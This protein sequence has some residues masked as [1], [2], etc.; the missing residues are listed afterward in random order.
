MTE[1]TIYF[2]NDNV[3][4]LR[5]VKAFGFNDK[6]LESIGHFG[7]GLKYAIAILKRLEHDI[8]L[9]LAG[10]VYVF[11]ISRVKGRVKEFEFITINDEEL[12]YTT[13]V[14]KNWELWQVY[15]ELYSNCLDEGGFVSTT[16]PVDYSGTVFE[17]TGKDFASIHEN[18]YQYVLDDSISPKES[19]ASWARYDTGGSIYSKGICVNKIDKLLYSYDDKLGDLQLTED[20]TVASDFSLNCALGEVLVQSKDI[21]YISKILIVKDSYEYKAIDLQY[22]SA[23]PSEEFINTAGLLKDKSDMRGLEAYYLKHTGGFKPIDYKPTEYEAAQLNE[24]IHFCQNNNYCVASYLIRIVEQLQNNALGLAENN[25]I[26]ISK[27]VFTTGGVTML[28]ATLIEEFIHLRYGYYDC[29]RELQNHLF[30][31]LVAALTEIT[32][33]KTKK[34]TV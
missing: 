17:I 14:G 10:K 2:C 25:T 31:K 5:A 19:S 33:M 23:K 4:D 34:E 16:P 20:R 15:R 13:E 30:E 7:T 18:R 24:A 32:F 8:T 21:V 12:A 3:M 27:E 22:C 9:T 26:F 6:N 11:S 1:Q 29:S 28:K